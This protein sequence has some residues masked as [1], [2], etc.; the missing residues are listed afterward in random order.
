MT[1]SDAGLADAEALQAWVGRAEVAEDEAAAVLVRRVAALLDRDPAPYVDGTAVPE[2]WHVAFFTPLA[3]QSQIGPDGHP[4]RGDFLP[5]VSLPRRMFAGRRLRFLAPIRIGAALR[6]T[7][8]IAAITPKRGRSGEMVFV[9]VE[10]AIAADGTLAVIEEQD[11]VYREEAGVAAKPG[12]GAAA[13]AEE[14][15]EPTDRESFVP[16]PVMLFRYSAI[17][18]NAHR[19]HYDAPYAQGE[20]GYPNLVVN[21]G[22]TALKLGELAKRNLPGGRLGRISLR[23]ERPFFLGRKAELRSRWEPDGRLSLWSVDERGRVLTRGEAF[24]EPGS[25]E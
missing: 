9:R 16:D 10:H 13:P 5:P 11:I 6:R 19:I 23:N 22:L 17:T 15:P 18:F 1:V 3:P 20:E 14:L 4:H 25:P 21:G 2:G 24:S 7:S 12:N 8:T